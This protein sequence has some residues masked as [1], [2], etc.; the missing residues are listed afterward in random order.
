MGHQ[1]WCSQK[2]KKKFVTVGSSVKDIMNKIDTEAD[3]ILGEGIRLVWTI[4]LCQFLKSRGVDFMFQTKKKGY[5]PDHD[6]VD[7]YDGAD[8]ARVNAAFTKGEEE[9]MAI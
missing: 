3:K 5:N 1:S 6:N 2:L 7:Y 4:D 8:P 9:G